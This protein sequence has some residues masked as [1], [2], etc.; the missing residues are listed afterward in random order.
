MNKKH[1]AGL[2]CAALLGAALLP[3]TALAA[4]AP[5][6]NYT[7]YVPAAH[8]GDAAKAHTIY[9]VKGITPP[10][11]PGQLEGGAATKGQFRLTD[12][13]GS[14]EK[15]SLAELDSQTT[16]GGQVSQTYTYM[17]EFVPGAGWYDAKKFTPYDL[18]GNPTPDQLLDGHSDAKLCWA[19]AA[20]NV[21]QWW[22]GQNS[23]QVTAYAKLNPENPGFAPVQGLAGLIPATD[24]TSESGLLVENNPVW[25]LLRTL[26]PKDQGF[27]PNK[28][29]DVFFNGYQVDF[30]KPERNRPGDLVKEA[31]AGFFQP[32]FGSRLLSSAGIDGKG[33]RY[34]NENLKTWLNEG[35]GI[36]ISHNIL[37]GSHA[38]TL[39]GAEYDENGRLCG[40]FVTDN[41]DGKVKFTD[42]A[43]AQHTFSM[44]RYDAF[45]TPAGML[46]ITNQV[47]PALR[48]QNNVN[49]VTLLY[50]ATAELDAYLK[51][52]TQQ[53]PAAGENFFPDGIIETK[54]H[55]HVYVYKP[56]GTTLV[57]SCN[58]CSES[59]T[60]RLELKG[61]PF[62]YN[63]SAHR[64]EL[65]K[66][67]SDSS[68]AQGLTIQQVYGENTN[69]GPGMVTAS[70]TI[71]NQLNDTNPTTVEITLPFTIEKNKGSESS[72]APQAIEITDTSIT[73]KDGPLYAMRNPD[74]SW[75]EFIETNQFT[76]LTAGNPSQFKAKLAE[77]LNYETV[78]E[79]AP[80][81]IT[82]L[83]AAAAEHL[84][85]FDANGEG[86]QSPLPS[87]TTSGGKLPSL[88]TASRPGYAFLGW[89]Q[90]AEGTGE[91]VT[92]ETVF[93]APATLYAK[94]EKPQLEG[95][96]GINSSNFYG[97]EFKAKYD[98]TQTLENPT[99]SWYRT[100]TADGADPELA[101]SG[102]ATYTATQEDVG[103][104]LRCQLTDTAH[105]GTL[106]WQSAYPVNKQNGPEFIVME[107]SYLPD[108][109]A[110]KI[111]AAPGFQ[112]APTNSEDQFTHEIPALPGG[113]FFVRIASTPVQEASLAKKV[114]LLPRPA[115]PQG[116]AS[117]EGKI[118]GVNN[119]MEYKTEG[120]SW[121]T[122]N[123]D[124]ITGLAA[125]TVVEIRLQATETAF[126]G[127]AAQIT[128]QQATK[129]IEPE[130]PK[131]TQQPTQQPAK[132]AV[133]PAPAQP[134]PAPQPAATPA[135]AQPTARPAATP[136]PEKAL[137]ATGS[138]APA[139]AAV[140]D[141]LPQGLAPEEEAAA[142]EILDLL[143]ADEQAAALVQ[144]PQL[145]Q[146]AQEAAATTTLTQAQARAALADLKPSPSQLANTRLVVQPYLE[147]AL[148]DAAT[149]KGSFTLSIRPM[150][151]TLATYAK[152]D[153]AVALTG[154]GANAVQVGKP[155]P[156]AVD[157]PVTLRLPL[158]EGF[159][160]TASQLFIEHVGY[161]YTGTVHSENGSRSLEFT[162]PHGFSDFTVT[163]QNSAAAQIGTLG[164]KNVKDALR[165]VENGG[166]IQL[167]SPCGETLQVDREI[168]F[169][170]TGEA[171]TGKI[172]AGVGL[173]CTAN[174][175]TY[176]VAAMQQPAATAQPQ[177]PAQ[178]S[179]AAPWL[180]LVLALALI[181]A[182]AGIVIALRRKR[183]D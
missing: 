172:V 14:V 105:Q 48:G 8:A 61:G 86:A 131:P 27:Y 11:M 180:W 124:A 125:G 155:Q 79:S 29:F 134:T 78:T 34:L 65:R 174:G 55:T 25:R 177:Q 83:T 60:L 106:V 176:T 142:R 41:N 84:I 15:G 153:E 157:Q 147:L 94:W 6:G 80:V 42:K 144:A 28:A 67:L 140:S 31:R 81:T 47:N 51:N 136:A 35:Y 179:S 139:Q 171:F 148:K 24:V 135:P 40:L 183:N 45:E 33:Y 77:S 37:Q 128:V 109:R 130:K 58:L 173:E 127:E 152:T 4:P 3:T 16:A 53:Q 95:S 85:T 120:G 118:T 164:Y 32:V 26:P 104:Y 178:G 151:R 167:L 52:Q 56:D 169:T 12:L 112:V 161:V 170:L 115:K 90:N 23:A 88:P 163:T 66:I 62:E 44:K 159:A 181:A 108:Y 74:G 160:P 75:G 5:T 98:G 92:G 100:A 137:A 9:W 129:P 97:G 168:S 76:G 145:N 39:W 22:L 156:A 18:L 68:L 103:K 54:P 1:L 10:A 133:T 102:T 126:A 64:P 17:T 162:N 43:G 71:R 149:Q 107:N 21:L 30:S 158:P 13:N 91:A 116:L 63:G 49:G 46:A 96:I 72:P 20:S 50:L 165:Q 99:F 123:G 141:S 175:S 132:P 73:L 101:A 119:R 138:K 36:T 182:V 93:E 114:S 117:A 150:L 59:A 57:R 19:A 70:I 87:L 143:A 7:Q 82:T 89:Y 166:S 111:V 38:I 113:S 121:A 154:K 69:A 110:E 146:L 122:V 2:A